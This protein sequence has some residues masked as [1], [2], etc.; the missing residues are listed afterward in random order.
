MEQGE[1]NCDTTVF[2]MLI[3]IFSTL[4]PVMHVS[5][6]PRPRPPT[7]CF[8]LN[9]IFP[10]FLAELHRSPRPR[11]ARV[12][13]PPSRREVP[14]TAALTPLNALLPSRLSRSS[15][16]PARLFPR[17]RVRLPR[18]APR[19]GEDPSALPPREGPRRAR[20]ALVCA[21]RARRRQPDH[22][23]A[24][25]GGLPRAE[26]RA[27]AGGPLRLRARPPA[28]P[29]QTEHALARSP[30]FRSERVSADV[31]HHISAL[32]L[33]HVVSRVSRRPAPPQL[34]PLTLSYKRKMDSRYNWVLGNTIPLEVVTGKA[35]VRAVQLAPHPISDEHAYS[36]TAPAWSRA[37]NVA[38][39]A[40][41]PQPLPLAPD[42]RWTQR[43]QR[44][45]RSCR[46]STRP[47]GR[48]GTE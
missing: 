41:P 42:C 12:S 15:A 7:H 30:P 16:L 26:A 13:A 40:T 39:H 37:L 14:T 20:D 28:N 21:P 46:T 5:A 24:H 31:Q 36:S 33:S 32:I 10:S 48:R 9:F 17:S 38:R 35:F 8:S 4:Q 45:S 6:R 23:P 27:G 18:P 29:A 34:A 25:H 44:M 3:V 1:V 22:L 2:F 11:A 47:C 19:R 43:A